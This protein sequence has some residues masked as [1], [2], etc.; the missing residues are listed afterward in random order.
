MPG[1]LRHRSVGS[2]STTLDLLR[3]LA[4]LWVIAGHA[5]I[6]AVRPTGVIG[7]LLDPIHAVGLFF[8]VS[9]YL[10]T[11]SLLGDGSRVS[12][13]RLAGAILR[14]WI[15]LAL[16][17]GAAVLLFSLPL[18]STLIATIGWEIAIPANPRQWL[19]LL[20]LFGAWTPLPDPV[21]GLLTVPIS[22]VVIGNWSI[23]AEWFAALLVIPYAA[24]R[25][26]SPRAIAVA[27]TLVGLLFSWS[28]L[29][30]GGVHW[31]LFHL[32]AFLVGVWA[33][34]VGAPISQHRG[35]LAVMLIGALLCLSTGLLSRS[36]SLV[37]GIEL[38]WGVMIALLLARPMPLRS[39]LWEPLFW[40]GSR[41][42]GAYL[43][44]MIG[45]AWSY[46]IAQTHLDGISLWLA[47]FSGGLLAAVL[48]GAVTGELLERPA[49]AIGRRL[50][51]KI[52]G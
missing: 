7:E 39:V 3:A 4:V 24:L 19:S 33:A 29:S 5:L 30:G 52:G 14:R 42:Y 12:R 27:A 44:H 43:F 20:T 25:L 35:D 34:R 32:P 31:A 48:G 23:S 40:L 37:P 47:I 22:I 1:A 28:S 50:A 18:I 11:R 15:R 46:S 21:L 6:V 45:L 41:S 36:G 2:R 51:R 16:P 49:I 38:L 13:A 10:V 17:H 8:A 9:G 26:R